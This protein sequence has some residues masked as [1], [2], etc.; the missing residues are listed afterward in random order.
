MKK[1]RVSFVENDLPRFMGH[2][3]SLIEE[4]GG[5]FLTGEHLT[6]ADIAAYQ[7][8][9][10]FRRG[11]ADHVPED[12]LEAYPQILKYLNRVEENEK[13]A[14]YMSSKDKS[15]PGYY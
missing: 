10:Y 6:I 9:H 14:V 15:V 13:M 4:N 7:M 5:H 3:A 11:I 2:F 8:I 12:C 1:L